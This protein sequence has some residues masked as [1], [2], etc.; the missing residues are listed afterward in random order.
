MDVRQD[1]G[2]VLGMIFVLNRYCFS[3]TQQ[4]MR[5]PTIFAAKQNKA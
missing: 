4:I 5:H 3:Q 2:M 1:E